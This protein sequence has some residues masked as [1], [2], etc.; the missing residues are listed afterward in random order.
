MLTEQDDEAAAPDEWV[1]DKILNHRKK[2]DGTVEFLTRWQG[3]QPE[4]DTWEP[5]KHFLQ[6]VNIDWLSYCK[7]HKIDFTVMQHMQHL[8]SDKGQTQRH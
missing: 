2:A 4:E 3:Y 7:L 5:V 1:V 6:K 8:L